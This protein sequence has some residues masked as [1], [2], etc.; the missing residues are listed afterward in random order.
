M[1]EAFGGGPGNLLDSWGLSFEN[2]YSNHKKLLD[3]FEEKSKNL[4]S[5][6]RSK[7]L[8]EMFGGLQIAFHYRPVEGY[9]SLSHGEVYIGDTAYSFTQ[10]NGIGY[11]KVDKAIPGKIASIS[12]APSTLCPEEKYAIL[13][14]AVD[15]AILSET[16]ENRGK[17]ELNYTFLIWHCNNIAAK[18]LNMSYTTITGDPF[19]GLTRQTYNVWNQTMLKA[20]DVERSL[21]DRF[22]YKKIDQDEWNK[23]YKSQVKLIAEL[24]KY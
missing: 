5:S 18:I 17:G 16:N 6:D 19:F 8:K 24:V 2:Y 7:L 23:I 1:Y 21:L 3:M 9:E 4:S 20:E 15:Y 13:K 12:L 14:R 11:I 10:T 22:K